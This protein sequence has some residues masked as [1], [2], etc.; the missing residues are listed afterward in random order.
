MSIKA[1][2]YLRVSGKSQ[3]EGDGFPRQQE[4]IA[5]AAAKLGYEITATFR[6]EG[7]SGASEWGDRPTFLDMVSR[8]L[9]GGAAPVIF[10]EN[11]TRL[12]RH[13][14]V[15]EN[16]LTYLASKDID[17][18]SSDT[19]ENVTQAIK[20]D[21]MK[22]AMIQMQAVFSQLEKKSL[23]RKL[24]AA[25]ERKK[26]ETGRCEGVKPFGMLD[27][28]E[29]ATF[30]VMKALRAQGLTVRAIADRLNADGTRPTRNGRPWH[31]ASV[32]KILARDLQDTPDESEPLFA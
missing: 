1:I 22:E 29:A 16:V 28:T 2:A 19:E 30:S 20:E 3:V 23:V 15:Q 27:A 14:R 26:A 24:K 8:I 25:R 9:D 12:A 6:D 7:V 4:A 21:P 18:I 17:L 10:V 11:L 13:V 5:K 31:Y 32:S